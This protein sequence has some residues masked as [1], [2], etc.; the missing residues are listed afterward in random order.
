MNFTFN[1]TFETCNKNEIFTCDNFHMEDV[2][3]RVLGHFAW[4]VEFGNVK[5]FPVL[6]LKAVS[7]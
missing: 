6:S 5:T 4:K 3:R 7:G 2:G 1:I